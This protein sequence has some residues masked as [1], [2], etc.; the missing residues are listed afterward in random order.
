MPTNEDLRAKYLANSSASS[1]FDY[2][3]FK[4]ALIWSALTTLGI[5]LLWL[6]ISLCFPKLAPII[7]HIL[8]AISL[9]T[10]GVLVLVLWD[11][12]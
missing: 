10:L 6:L 4:W 1:P 9:I 3:N 2:Q 5:S 12:Y 7:A 8:G 11:K